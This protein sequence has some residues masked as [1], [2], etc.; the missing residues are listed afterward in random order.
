MQFLQ[1][2]AVVDEPRCEPI[3]KLGMSRQL[4]NLAEVTGSAH[5]AFAKVMLP[6]A[7]DDHPGCQ[8]VVRI[9]DPAGQG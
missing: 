5:K 2:P 3:E 7:V 8:R 6:N 1:R 9:G 4:A